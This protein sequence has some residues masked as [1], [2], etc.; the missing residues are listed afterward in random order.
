MSLYEEIFAK[1]GGSITEIVID[2]EM[3][4]R[5]SLRCTIERM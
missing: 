5:I 4:L 3:S 2:M 1:I